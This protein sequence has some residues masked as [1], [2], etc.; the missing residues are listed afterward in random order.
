MGFEAG[1]DAP[2]GR[3]GRGDGATSKPR[4]DLIPALR[5]STAPR[6]GMVVADLHE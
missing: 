3:T 1:A 6:D 2:E 5:H 4:T